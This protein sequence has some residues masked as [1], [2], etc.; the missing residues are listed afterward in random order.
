MFA[1]VTGKSFSLLWKQAIFHLLVQLGLVQHSKLPFS[2][3][4]A[5]VKINFVH[6]TSK[7]LLL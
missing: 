7:A 2:N 4:T 5:L 1:L 3:D 6:C